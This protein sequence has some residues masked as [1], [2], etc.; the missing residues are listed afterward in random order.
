MNQPLVWLIGLIL[1]N[2]AYAETIINGYVP[3]DGV[4]NPHARQQEPAPSW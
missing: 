3:K 4:C 1:V 2:F